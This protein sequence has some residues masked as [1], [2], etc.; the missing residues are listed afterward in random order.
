MTELHIYKMKANFK[1]NQLKKK[2]TSVKISYKDWNV[3]N[4]AF[5]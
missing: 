3:N 2:M 4:F 5:P 1:I